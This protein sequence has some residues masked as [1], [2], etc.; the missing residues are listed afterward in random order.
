[1]DLDF[2]PLWLTLQLAGIT[3]ALLLLPGLALAW[4]L[5]RWKSPWRALLEAV[6]ALPLVLPPVVLGFY[7]LLLLG[8]Q[9]WVGRGLHALGLPG[10]LTFSFSGLVVGSMIYSLPFMV[11]PLLRAFDELPQDLLDA[12]ATLRAGAWDRFV[13]VVL[14]LSR[15]GLI[16]GLTLAFAH[17]LGEFGVVLMLGGNIP[18]R[19]RV[20]SI[21]IYNHVEAMEYGQAHLLSAI[22]LGFAL[23][24]LALVYGLN[25]RARA[26]A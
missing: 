6:V 24:V 3:T 1:M 20:A 10:Q 25:A 9:G 4:R 21:D 13:H 5:A 23:A 16:G 19:T 18:G 15:G 14:P 17:T 8:P 2:G 11:Q 7:L 22:L 12:A 26:R